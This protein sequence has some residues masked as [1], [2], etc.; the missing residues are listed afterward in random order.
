M[1]AVDRNAH[2]GELLRTRDIGPLPREPKTGSLRR[3]MGK[4]KGA[5][6]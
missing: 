2:D 3:T 4:A 5:I 1:L 6:G